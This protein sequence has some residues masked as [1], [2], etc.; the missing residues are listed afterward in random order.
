MYLCPRTSIIYY[1]Y[2][3][4]YKDVNNLLQLCTCVLCLLGFS[5]LLRFSELSCIRMSDI[6]WHDNYR[7]VNIP[8]NKTDIYRRRHSMINGKTDNELCPIYW[9]KRYIL[10]V[11]LSLG[12]EEFVLTAINFFFRLLKVHRRWAS[13]TA[14]DGYIEDSIEEKT[15]VSMNLGL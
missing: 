9:L 13:E 4:V 15:L 1:N 8:Q 5:G 6:V 12:S 2:V 11:G 14:K 10:L 3:P 7:K